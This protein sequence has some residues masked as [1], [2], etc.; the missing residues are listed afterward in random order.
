M[1]G[2]SPAR[3]HGALGGI[4]CSVVCGF[5]G[6]SLFPIASTESGFHLAGSTCYYLRVLPRFMGRIE[7]V[8]LAAPAFPTALESVPY[9]LAV[10]S[11]WDPGASFVMQETQAVP[12][13]LRPAFPSTGPLTHPLPT[14]PFG[15]S[16]KRLLVA[17]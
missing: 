1:A 16:A 17:K 13:R 8:P 5:Y 2:S 10:I 14:A 15:H 7:G 3:K 6:F 12:R 9:F 11:C 4:L